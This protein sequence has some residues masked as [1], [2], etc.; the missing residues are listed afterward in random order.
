MGQG[1]LLIVSQTF[2]QGFLLNRNIG[3]PFE[4]LL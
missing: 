1:M 2:I 4:N 3:D